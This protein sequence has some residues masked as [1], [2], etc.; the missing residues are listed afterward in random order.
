MVQEATE[1]LPALQP[2]EVVEDRAAEEQGQLF[3]RYMEI[4]GKLPQGMFEGA[5][6]LLQRTHPGSYRGDEKKEYEFLATQAKNYAEAAKIAMTPEI[7]TLYYILRANKDD[8]LLQPGA[9][10]PF[11]F[12]SD[13]PILAEALLMLGEYSKYRTFIHFYSGAF[14]EELDR[15]RRPRPTSQAA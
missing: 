13:P 3:A 4:G 8:V 1:T 2:A 14:K 10:K 15:E 9:S 11:F 6:A 7:K 12:K 5:L